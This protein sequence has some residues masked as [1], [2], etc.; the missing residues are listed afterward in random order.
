MREIEEKIADIC[1][2]N[3]LHVFPN[4]RANVLLILESAEPSKGEK[5]EAFDLYDE[6]C[7]K[8]HSSEGKK[9]E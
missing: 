7:C 3:D 4:I 9:G 5:L 6:W 2:R 8:L 1:K